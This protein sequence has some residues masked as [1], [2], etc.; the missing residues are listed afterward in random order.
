[1]VRRRFERNRLAVLVWRIERGD[2]DCG[3]WKGLGGGSL[4]R[5][6]FGSVGAITVR[7]VRRQCWPFG[8]E[9]RGF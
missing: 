3:S 4:P 6:S 9:I 2:G 1:M 8:D 5:W 7:L